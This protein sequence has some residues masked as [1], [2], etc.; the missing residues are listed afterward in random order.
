M[1]LEK[2][3]KV[4]ETRKTELEEEL[5]KAKTERASLDDQKISLTIANEN[6]ML[7]GRLS[8]V[9][10]AKTAHDAKEHAWAKQKI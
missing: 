10:R 1:E 2:A 6:G 5:N 7:M 8:R 9:D 3:Q 4:W